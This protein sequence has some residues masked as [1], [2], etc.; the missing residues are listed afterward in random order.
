MTQT[1][2]LIY[3]IS[4]LMSVA[5]FSCGGE[6]KKPSFT[7]NG[8]APGEKLDPLKLKGVGPIKSLT[9]DATINE[10]MAA[11]G[12]EIFDAKCQL[13]HKI[14]ARLVGPPLKGVAQQRTP[15]WIMNMMLNPMEMIEK[16][17]LAKQLYEE[18]KSPMTPQ[19]LSEEEAREILE[20]LRTI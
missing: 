13:C 18:Y 12:K 20:Y 17:P 9:L 3:I 2:V 19:G 7:R 6:K 4:L 10:E 5:V 14:E 11:K 1:K 8:V 15:E 16:D